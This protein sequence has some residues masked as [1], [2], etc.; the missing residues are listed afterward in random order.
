MT[1]PLEIE[2]VPETSWFTNL[3][4]E[5]TPPQWDALR[6][7]VYR[8]A[9]YRCEICGG[10]GPQ[11]PV[12]AHE[13]WTY[14]PEGRQELRRIVALCPDCHKCKHPGLAQLNGETERVIVHL[15]KVN[16]QT[17][18]ETDAQLRDAF[19]LWR[20]RSARAWTLDIARVRAW[21]QAH[22]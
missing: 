9:G 7:R 11:W 10:K 22:A 1:R 16:A 3:R 15:M 21:A 19:T 5:L 14:H 18:A 2:L 4:S 17:R 8:R 12:E 20:E 13:E 6:K